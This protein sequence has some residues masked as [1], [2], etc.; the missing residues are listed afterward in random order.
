MTDSRL[1]T[2]V[3][4]ITPSLLDS[5]SYQLQQ[6]N[7]GIHSFQDERACSKFII[8][9]GPQIDCLILEEHPTS[10]AILSR[11][12]SQDILLP[13]L[14]ITAQSQ[15]SVGQ[16]SRATEPLTDLEQP[17]EV[18]QE[19]PQNQPAS[20]VTLIETYHEAVSRLPAEAIR[21]ISSSIEKAI[22]AFLNLPSKFDGEGGSVAPNPMLSQE[23][24]DSLSNQQRRLSA[25]LQERLGYFGVYYKRDQKLFLRNMTKEDKKK[26]LANLR[27]DY[28]DIILNYFSDSSN[29]NKKIDRYVT[30]AFF[31]DVP[32][33]QI[34]EVHMELMD[35][36]SKQL[37]L[38]G[39]SEEILLDYRL[40]LIDT[41]ANLC[42]LYRRSI[43]RL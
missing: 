40:T 5:L 2:C 25:K 39:R 8:N 6:G 12:H 19:A 13:V 32:T 28:R 42:E 31:A 38:E 43:P 9:E 41:V 10:N 20:N 36:F 30:T 26:F 18:Y 34:V 37:K 3:F 27:Q 16:S 22:H 15:G 11:L 33:A 29:L 7:F 35:E 4:V 14:L 24:T 23:I 1:V 17:S 21:E